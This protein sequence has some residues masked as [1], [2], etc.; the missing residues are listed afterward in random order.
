MAPSL[1]L[2]VLCLGQVDSHDKYVF[3]CSTIGVLVL[4]RHSRYHAFPRNPSLQ[5]TLLMPYK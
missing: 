5:T 1:T 4:C 2:Q 3:L